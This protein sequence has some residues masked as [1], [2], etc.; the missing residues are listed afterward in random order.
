MAY[1]VAL[2]EDNELFRLKIESMLNGSDFELVKQ[3][4]NAEQAKNY[5]SKEEPDILIVDLFING[6]PDGVELILDLKPSKT[7]IIAISNSSDDAVYNKL[8]KRIF[9]YLVKPFHKLS[10]MSLLNAATENLD[11]FKQSSYEIHSIFLTG[12]GGRKDRVAID[13]IRYIEVE[14]NYSFIHTSSNKYASKTSLTKF[15]GS[16][17]KGHFLRIHNK[18]AVGKSWIKSITKQSVILNDGTDLSIG[19]SYK[20]K[21]LKEIKSQ[22]A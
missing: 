22:D 14:G 15:L 16:I 8:K 4:T 10:M 5:L 20:S 21:I 6:K 13:S 1:S 12:S 18:Y 17:P 3:C 11:L 2:L 19:I 7:L 9:S